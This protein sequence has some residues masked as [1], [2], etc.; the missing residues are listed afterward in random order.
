MN[1]CKRFLG[2]ILVAGCAISAIARELE[3]NADAI[4]SLNGKFQIAY[5]IE[6]EPNNPVEAFEPPAFG[7]HFKVIAGPGQSVA[8]HDINGKV[9]NSIIFTYYLQALRE[10]VFDIP[11]ASVK[12]KDG[13]V[14]KSKARSMEVLKEEGGSGNAQQQQNAANGDVS[15]DD[16]FIRM[17]FSR[18]SVYKGEP[19]VLTIKLYTRNVHVVNVSGFK[20]PTLAGFDMQEL[21]IAD[22]DWKQQKYNNKIYQTYPLARLMLYPLRAG[23]LKM[24]PVELVATIQVRQQVRSNSMMDMIMGP[25]IKHINKNLRSSPV[26]LNIKDFP[27]GAPATFNGATGNF[28]LISKIDKTES[29]ANQPVTFAVTVSGSGNFK[30]IKEPLI[31][32]PENFDKYDPKIAENVKSEVSGG[33][34]SKKF[35]YVVIPRNAGEFD[36]PPVEFSY[37]DVQKGSYVSLKTEPVHLVI[38]RDPNAANS[39]PISSMPMVTGKKVKHL[40][41]DILFIKTDMPQLSAIGSVF[42]GSL[43]FWLIFVAMAVIF[44]AAVVMRTKSRKNR[45]NVALMRNKKANKVAV[46][47]LKQSAKFLKTDNRTAFYEEVSRAVWG[48]IGDKLNMQASELSRDNI[49]D[50]LNAQNVPQENVDLLIAVIDNCEYARYAPGGSREGMEEVYRQALLAISNLENLK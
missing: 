8:R 9:S 11:Q 46:S 36:I 49:Q 50:K 20:M 41:N 10:G 23:E 25:S 43:D 42:F 35:E 22:P 12:M 5:T 18:Q 29:V 2:F 38:E 27:A 6:Y 37:F 14:I 17:E 1:I 28:K 44:S 21:K 13:S 3:V 32:F 15:A 45:Q 26:S 19:M 47:R 31:V 4:V 24:D 48:Y 16:L 30:Q 33:T 40:G 7:D 34:G 39:A